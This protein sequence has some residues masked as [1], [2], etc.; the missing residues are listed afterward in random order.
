MALTQREAFA[1][2]M[3]HLVNHDSHGYTQGNRWGNG[4]KETVDLGDGVSV[5]VMEGDRDC[6]SAIISALIAVGIDTGDATYTGNMKRNILNTGL[7]EWKGEEFIA[8]RGDIYLNEACHTAMSVDDESTRLAEF[9]ISENG[10][11]YGEEGDQTGYESRFVGYYNYP[12]D[13]ILHWKNDGATLGGSSTRSASVQLFDAN[14]TNAQKFAIEWCDDNTFMLRNLS[15]NLYLDVE[16]A[17]T[18]SGATVQVYTG[19]GTI[20]QKWRAVQMGGGYAPSFVQPVY[21][22]PCT[23]ENLALDVGGGSTDNGARIQVYNKNATGAQQWQV[24]DHGDGTWTLIN[25][26]SSKALDV[27]NGGN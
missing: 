4:R 14:N 7:F 8:G 10:T 5:E 15:C 27:V 6:S 25:V 23:N 26:H 1:R 22:V 11:I 3:E 21:I 2:T 20:A 12:W 13:G 9:A 19:N 18:K 24:L 17:S 16:G